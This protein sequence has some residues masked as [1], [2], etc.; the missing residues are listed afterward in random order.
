MILLRAYSILHSI[1]HTTFVLRI[2]DV[3]ITSVK[4][5]IIRV[6]AETRLRQLK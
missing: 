6:L 5:V 2:V 1:L 3:S 4:N